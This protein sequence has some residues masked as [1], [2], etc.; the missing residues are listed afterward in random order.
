MR[1]HLIPVQAGYNYSQMDSRRVRHYYGT[2][3]ER[4][5]MEVFLWFWQTPYPQLAT[6]SHTHWT[7]ERSRTV[8]SS[9]DGQSNSITLR[10]LA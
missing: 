3:S 10:I 5:A 9:A 6:S 8:S 1:A 4:H 7:F 2:G